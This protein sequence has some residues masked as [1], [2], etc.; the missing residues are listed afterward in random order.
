[1]TFCFII[2]YNRLH[3]PRRMADYL[4]G[5]KGIVPVIVD[6]NS[7]Y[8]PLL[9]YY[10]TTP[11]EVMRLDHNHG[12]VAVWYCGA[13]DEYDISERYVV[14]DPDL[15]IDRIPRDWLQVLGEGLDRYDF[16]WKVG[17]GLRI[18][19]LPDTP[20]GREA[21]MVEA[22]HWAYPLDGLYYQ[23]HIDTTFCLYRT[24]I[25]HIAAVR[26]GEPY[27]ARHLPWYW[28]SLAD[29]PP[30]E[31]YYMQSTKTIGSNYWTKR[32][33]EGFNL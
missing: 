26:T 31:L 15:E 8:P 6:N 19:D 3:Y 22:P 18:D 13:L 28:A 14:T 12:Q 27:V 2:N 11:H 17:F 33:K 25:N 24:R 7:D 32:L 21:R 23:A 10:E 29:V 4:A 1:M 30:D 20:V 5:C 9:E 16:A